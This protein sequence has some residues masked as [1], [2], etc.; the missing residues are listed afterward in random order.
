MRRKGRH[1]TQPPVTARNVGSVFVMA[2]ELVFTVDGDVAH[3]AST[4]TLAEAGLR[5]REH[6]QEWVPVRGGA[7]AHRSGGKQAPR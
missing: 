5:E 6:L 3:A 7:S 1:S 2:D 4:I